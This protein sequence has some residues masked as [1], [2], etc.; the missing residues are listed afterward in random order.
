M[1]DNELT[2]ITKFLVD[3]NPNSPY[4][5][6][7]TQSSSNGGNGGKTLKKRKSLKGKNPRR[8]TLYKRKLRRKSIHKIA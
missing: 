1:N 7:I 5:S 6:I 2:K 8:K 3:Y 4:E